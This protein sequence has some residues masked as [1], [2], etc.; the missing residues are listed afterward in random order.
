M[1]T[2]E[3]FRTVFKF[4]GV[5]GWVLQ[6][7]VVVLVTLVASYVLRRV[8]KRV[9]RRLERTR[10]PWDTALFGALQTPLGVLI[11]I[12]GVTFA[13][14]IIQR[15]AAVPIFEAAHPI[16]DVGIIASLVWFLVRFIRNAEANI[17]AQREAAGQAYDRTTLDA[18]SKL[19]RISVIITGALVALQTLGFSVSGVLAFG[20]IGGLAVGFAAKDLLA[21]FFGGLMVYLDRPFAVGDWVR[22]PDRDME[23]TVEHIGW[24][25][26]R[27]RTFDQRP[28]YVPN[29]TFTSV[30]VENPSRMLNRRIFETIGIRYDDAAKMKDIVRDVERMLREHPE[31]DQNRTLM[32]NFNKFAASSLDFFIYTFTKTVKW[33]EYHAIKQDVLLKIMDIIL[34]HGAEVAFPT[35]TVHVPEGL[36]LR[37][38]GAETSVQETKVGDK[39]R[40]G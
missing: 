39:R 6:V 11:W 27:I 9:Y 38:E 40:A 5:E 16:R 34:A 8:L 18:I 28:L 20:G 14:D 32:V 15:E 29:A 23:G 2:A 13:I 30:A 26:T 22:S 1:D 36:A 24:R 10:T 17:I 7:F 12:V 25:L 31:I 19:L 4:L 33:T 37:D 21:N 35:S 3:V